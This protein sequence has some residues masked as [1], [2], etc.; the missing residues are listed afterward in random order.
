MQAG[1]PSATRIGAIHIPVTEE[2]GVQEHRI[3]LPFPFFI[4]VIFLFA[5]AS[6][7]L[8]ISNLLAMAS[9]Y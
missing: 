5:M 3:F 1:I 8:A 9:T 7:L 6:N 4:F 2:P